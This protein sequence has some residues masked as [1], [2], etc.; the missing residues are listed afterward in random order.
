[1]SRPKSAAIFDLD[2]TLALRGE[3]SP[4]DWRSVGLDTP[5]QPLVLI[6]QSLHA[7]KIEILIVSGREDVCRSDT[8]H[9][10]GIHLGFVPL[11]FMRTTGDNRPDYEI[12]EEIYTRQ[13]EP[14][15]HV[16]LVFD[17]RQQ[18]VD[19]WRRLGITTLQVAPGDF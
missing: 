14:H 7:H 17:D 5:N 6:L 12:K 19:L 1:M 4:Y 2:G 16:F 11:T 18:T 10:L 3:R 9:W 15:W 13:I 8:E